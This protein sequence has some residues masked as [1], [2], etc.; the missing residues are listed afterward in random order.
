MLSNVNVGDTLLWTHGSS[1]ARQQSLIVVERVTD[2]QI[3]TKAKKF[4]KSNGNEIG[5]LKDSF[6]CSF[7]R[8]TTEEEIAKLKAEKERIARQSAI[9]RFFCLQQGARSLSEEDA[10]QVL[11]I[12]SK[13]TEKK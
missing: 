8:T 3:I 9:D 6:Y 5:K 13:Y 11:T 2:T 1:Y 7:V 12:I 10:N 4:R